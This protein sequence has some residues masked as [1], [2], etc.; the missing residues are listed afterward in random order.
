MTFLIFALDAYQ[1]MVDQTRRLRLTLITLLFS[2]CD[3]N[4]VARAE[5]DAVVSY[6]EELES[7][8]DSLEFE[9]ADL[10]LYNDYLEKKLDTLE[11]QR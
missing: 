2:A 6:A 8:N 3:N 7:R 10:K 11:H 1:S 9:L 4:L 5:Y